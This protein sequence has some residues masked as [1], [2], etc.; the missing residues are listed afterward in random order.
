[1]FSPR[2]Y[3]DALADV[4][5]ALIVLPPENRDVRRILL[6]LKDEI[7]GGTST[8]S[9]VDTLHCPTETSL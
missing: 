3:E 7:K 4:Q 8:A 9:S 2:L 5:E 6:K 1:M